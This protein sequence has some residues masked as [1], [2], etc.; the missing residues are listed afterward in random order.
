VCDMMNVLFLCVCR[1]FVRYIGWM[2]ALVCV[3]AGWS[4]RGRCWCR[5]LC[6]CFEC[7]LV[8][9][10]ARGRLPPRVILRLLL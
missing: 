3:D 8:C 5:M 9:T 6:A 4:R 1:V 7:V 10:L 2:G